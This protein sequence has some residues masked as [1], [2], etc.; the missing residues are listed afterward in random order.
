MFSLHLFACFLLLV[1][2]T[3]EEKPTDRMDRVLGHC[4]GVALLEVTE[5]K[6]VD[7]RGGSGSLDLVVT[8]K[9]TESW[10]TVDEKF[11][12][13]LEH[14]G[15]GRPQEPE[16]P[17]IDPETIQV[18][19]KYWIAFDS[20]GH[21]GVA[22]GA[23]E[24][25]KSGDLKQKVAELAAAGHFDWKRR[26][27]NDGLVLEY[28]SLDENGLVVVKDA[29]AKTMTIRVLRDGKVLWTKRYES[30]IFGYYFPR[31]GHGMVLQHTDPN[32]LPDEQLVTCGVTVVL[33]A[34]NEWQLPP[35]K[36]VLNRSLEAE[37]GKLRMAEVLKHQQGHA[38]YI[39]RLYDR[40]GRT[41]ANAEFQFRDGVLYKTVTTTTSGGG[42][43]VRRFQTTGSS[44]QYE[45]IKAK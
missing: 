38:P 9:I 6:Q 5:F 31:F 26:T 1:S 28:Q 42:A 35:G 32:H 20:H 34:A 8:G 24:E 43:Q 18:G 4:S 23:W 16:T 29:D 22:A 10:G 45:E 36:Y 14:G 11:N 15:F 25:E 37:T 21:F 19:Q 2:A 3:Q 41:L 13:V 44:S 12:I 17:I 33:P 30:P 40:V 27:Q 7:T 39:Q